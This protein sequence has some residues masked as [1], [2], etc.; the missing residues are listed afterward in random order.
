MHEIAGRHQPV[1]WLLS[2]S[3][4]VIH[5]VLQHTTSVGIS[6][7]SL[8]RPMA[9]TRHT[10]SLGGVEGKLEAYNDTLI[11]YLFSGC[12]VLSELFGIYL[13]LMPLLC[14]CGNSSS[15]CHI[16]LVTLWY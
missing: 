15:L 3:M 9:S 8:S 7:N 13:S 6:N 11:L 16:T 10:L 5:T 1:Q 12:S 2:S 4:L 14:W